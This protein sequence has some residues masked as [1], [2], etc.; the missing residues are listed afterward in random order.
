MQRIEYSTGLWSE[1]SMNKLN[2]GKIN[3]KESV[4]FSADAQIG[5]ISDWTAN[6][7]KQAGKNPEDFCQIEEKTIAKILI[8]EIT[9]CIE[10]AREKK[11]S[12]DKAAKNKLEADIASGIAFPTVKITAQYGADLIWARRLSADEKKEYAEWYREIGLVSYVASKRIKVPA[13]V[14]RQVINGRKSSGSFMGCENQAWIITEAEWEQ[15]VILSSKA[16]AEKNVAKEKCSDEEDADIKRKIR[17]GYCFACET[18]CDGDCG[19]YS[20]DP[21]FGYIKQDLV[22]VD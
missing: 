18:Y 15:I 21:N 9:K 6:A 2:Y 12:E 11:L 22:S 7:I 17:M 19:N 5:E 10:F 4:S 8:P 13:A 1:R 3:I 14:V 16:A 20:K